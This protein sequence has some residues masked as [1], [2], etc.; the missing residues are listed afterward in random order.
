VA[1]DK[2]TFLS[3]MGG[4][5]RDFGKEPRGAKASFVLLPVDGALP[6]TERAALEPLPRLFDFSLQLAF[7]L[8]PQ[9]SR[10]KMIG[11]HDNIIITVCEEESITTGK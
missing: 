1:A 11:G 2:R 10:E 6:G 8:C 4:V 7:L 5:G 9:V 3:E